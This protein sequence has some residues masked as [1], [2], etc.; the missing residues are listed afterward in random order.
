MGAW[1]TG[2]EDALARGSGRRRGEELGFNAGTWAGIAVWRVL[3]H[4]AQRFP[5]VKHMSISPVASHLLLL[6]GPSRSRVDGSQ[7]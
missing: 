1:E 5:T 7:P 6:R 3:S 2:V 4:R